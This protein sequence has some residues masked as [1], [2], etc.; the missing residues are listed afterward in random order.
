MRFKQFFAAA[1]IMAGG[2][3]G[4][5]VWAQELPV[6]SVDAGRSLGPVNRQVFGHN[7]SAGD[8]RGMFSES[9]DAPKCN[10]IGIKFGEGFWDPDKM[11]PYPQPFDQLR[12]LSPGML[13]YPG[14]CLAH[15]FNWKKAVGPLAER[16]DWRFG[17]D[18]YIQFCRL[19]K[20][21]PLFT[22]SD[23][24]L[25][26]AEMPQHLAELVEYL[27]APA[28]P[29]HP[30][31]MKRAAWGHPE[32]YRVKWFELGNETDH[33]NHRCLPGRRFSA[34]DYVDYVKNVSA[35]MKKVDPSIRIGV[36]TVPGSGEDFACEWNRSVYRGA[37]P[38]ADFVVV[39]FYGPGIDGLA[40]VAGLKAAMAFSSQL[41]Y[42]LRKYHELTKEGCGRD[43]PLAVTEFNID[44]AHDLR[45][46]YTS[47]L[48]CADLMR[49]WLKPEN[50][51]AT[52]NYWHIMNGVFGAFDSAGG[53]ISV[54]RATLPFMELWGSHFGT[55]LVYSSVVN[56]P[57]GDSAAAKGLSESRGQ[58]MEESRVLGKIAPENYDASRLTKEGVAVVANDNGGFRITFKERAKEIYLEFTRVNRPDSALIK[59]QS[60]FVYKLSFDA[61]Y[62]AETG[63]AA[64]GLGMCDQRGWT[65]THS[66]MAVS[67][68]QYA[69]DWKHYQQDFSVLPDCPGATVLV[70]VENVDGKVSGLL[71]IRNMKIEVA[72]P[73]VFP[74]YPLLTTS[75]SLS[76]DG[77]T[78]YLMVFNKSADQAISADVKLTDFAA[79]GGKYFELFKENPFAKE[80][81][82]PTTGALTVSGDRLTHRFPPHSMT[83]IELYRR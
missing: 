48:L 75:S 68:L 29:D 65:K 6:I 78:L 71:E 38:Y 11:A 60:T 76:A 7:I 20:V 57:V 8:A 45:L 42:R 15:N 61:R 50:G 41:E 27:N 44:A 17:I 70:R 58:A 4:G 55:Q 9:F 72:S 81:F 79:A 52:A 5:D 26:A 32:P 62:K 74:A 51:I 10:P 54:R 28:T 23:Y 64:L 43:L 39:H 67:G 21:E 46:S 56:S 66:A 30:W 34:E 13:R 2:I 63:K 40:P 59:P 37:A 14:G 18:E 83:A 12:K 25:P 24:V 19:L 31:A 47:G 73:S 1:V 22:L 82:T 33:G 3:A 77:R 16:G 35:A 53:K 80:Y 49:I 36:V 69:G